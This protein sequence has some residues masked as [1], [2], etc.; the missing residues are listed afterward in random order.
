M[1]EKTLKI[2]ITGGTRGLGRKMTEHLCR[3][4]HEVFIFSKS[5]ETEIDPSFLS[6]LAGYAKCD[7][8]KTNELE[9]CFSTLINNIERIDVLINNAAVRQFKELSEFQTSEIQR[10]IDVDFI[11]PVILSNLCLPIMKRH[12]FGR[13]INIS[14]ISAYRSYKT[15]SLYCS[16]KH[17]LVDFSECLSKE[18][19]S[20]R[21]AITVNTICPDSFSKPDGTMLKN[22]HQITD[23]ILVS[24]DRIIQSEANG[25]VI[26]EFNF[27]NKLKESLRFIKRAIQ[28]LIS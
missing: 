12:N 26:N 28:M 25:M 22:Y 3:Q 21:G 24:I 16:A 1:G 23:S 13:I 9:T 11:A 18:F 8:S 6:I 5:S 2:L 7:L 4:G 10:N 19:I 15:G 27:Q 17:A 14:S 20:L